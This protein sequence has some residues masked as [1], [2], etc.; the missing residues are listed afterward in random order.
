MRYLVREVVVR[1]IDLDN[2]LRFTAKE[3]RDVRTNCS[4]TTE[5]IAKVTETPQ[6]LPKQDFFIGHATT[7]ALGLT[8][9]TCSRLAMSLEC[10]RNSR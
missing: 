10:H 1:A 3:V 2:K 6:L 4:L 5:G 9:A 8:C 7:Q